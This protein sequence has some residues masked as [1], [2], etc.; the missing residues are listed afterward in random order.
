MIFGSEGHVG[1][2]RGE[3]IDSVENGPPLI[4]P[5]FRKKVEKNEKVEKNGEN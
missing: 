2:L 4:F 3:R 5:K 1:M